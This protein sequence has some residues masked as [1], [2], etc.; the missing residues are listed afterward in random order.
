[1]R[2]VKPYGTRRGAFS[3]YYVQR[4][5]LH[6]RI[7]NFFN[8]AAQAMNF[9]DKE[10][11]ALAEVSQKSRQIA[12]F[13][14]RRSR[15]NSQVYTHLVRNYSGK[16]CLPQTGR[17]VQQNVVERVAALFCRLDVNFKVFF[18]LF[19]TYVLRQAFRS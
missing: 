7:E 3:Y 18:R 13:F 1:M 12:L 19:L 9:I 4:I 8:A 17:A 16:R 15:C 14:Y 11:V 10:N 2:Q 5:I 6:R